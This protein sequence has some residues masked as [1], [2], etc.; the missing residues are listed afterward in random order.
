MG[1]RLRGETMCHKKPVCE[2]YIARTNKGLEGA[3]DNCEYIK[4]VERTSY[5]CKIGL[6]VAIVIFMLTTCIIY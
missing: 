2:K 3:C 1:P 5:L 6:V 4:K